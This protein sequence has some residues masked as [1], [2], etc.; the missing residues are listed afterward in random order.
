M[1]EKRISNGFSE[2]KCMCQS[3][4]FEDHKPLDQLYKLRKLSMR[5]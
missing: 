2:K 5:L 3:P 1:N 4:S